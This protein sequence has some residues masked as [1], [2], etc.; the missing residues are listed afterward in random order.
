MFPRKAESCGCPRRKDSSFTGFKDNE[1]NKIAF[2]TITET[3]V[4]VTVENK[5]KNLRLSI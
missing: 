2:K 4:Q 5:K 3:F 1:F